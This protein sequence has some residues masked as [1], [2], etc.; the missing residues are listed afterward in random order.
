MTTRRKYWLHFM[1]PRPPTVQARAQVEAQ[2]ALSFG[3]GLTSPVAAGA[4]RARYW[5]M[6]AAA[7]LDWE[8]RGHGRTAGRPDG[9]GP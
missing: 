3:L 4:G 1:I 5:A 6:L 2:T 8:R 9:D 7:R